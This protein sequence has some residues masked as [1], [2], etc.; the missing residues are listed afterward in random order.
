MADETLHQGQRVRVKADVQY[1][2]HQGKVGTIT[3]AFTDLEG[4]PRYMVA[5]DDG[6]GSV[7]RAEELELLE[8]TTDA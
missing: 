8:E 6:K 5:F 2:L 7:Y 4:R 1:T 3:S